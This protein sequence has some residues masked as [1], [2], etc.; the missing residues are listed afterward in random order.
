[1]DVLD[2]FYN[3]IVKE[4]SQ[5]KIKCFF[6]YS[7]FFETYFKET[8]DRISSSIEFED[9]LIPTL[10]IHNKKEFDELLCKYVDLCLDFYGT[11]NYKE[12]ILN[13]ENYN[14]DR[15][16][17]EKLIMTTLWANATFDDFLEPEEYLR[18]RI[19]FLENSEEVSFNTNYSEL[20][21][22]SINFNVEKDKLVFETPNKIKIKL[23]S[24]DNLEYEFPEVKF[25]IYNDKVYFY[26]IQNNHKEENSYSK[27][28]N[29]LLFKIG[30]GFDTNKDNYE[31]YEE[32][33]LKDVS[34]S[35]IVALNIAISYFHSLGY[36]DI[37]VPNM[38]P[39]RWN[40]KISV[41]E[42][43]YDLGKISYK[44]KINLEEK[45][46]DIQKNLT[47][48]FIRTFL[49]LAHH[50]DGM[51]IESLPLELDSNLHISLDDELVS[52]NELLNETSELIKNNKINRHI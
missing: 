29:R 16:S 27:K 17:P 48:K 23:V 24:E 51:N 33:N 4:A 11:N 19:S 52:N 12:E 3:Y 31:I 10:T 42:R 34:A 13:C 9:K 44:E 41:L 30:E 26:A 45:I 7:I 5:G 38:L 28:V 43:K 40:S 2:I 20:L 25:G 37:V 49:I 36:K 21:K 15:T 35:F 22:G 1:M 46:I 32:G 18:K 50:Y 8:K 39:A 14:V 47:E 6:T